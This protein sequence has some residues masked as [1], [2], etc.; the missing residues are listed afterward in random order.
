MRLH[1]FKGQ[2]QHI[3]RGGKSQNFNW[4]IHRKEST[5]LI[6]HNIS[7]IKIVGGSCITI[8]ELPQKQLLPEGPPNA[9]CFKIQ[10][11]RDESYKFELSP[12]SDWP[13]LAAY[14]PIQ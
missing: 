12:A 4:H 1:S 9:A 5:H 11:R 7:A 10:V 8:P 13:T 6:S 14:N 2:D 3:I